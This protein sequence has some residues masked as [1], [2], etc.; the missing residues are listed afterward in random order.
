MLVVS[1]VTLGSPEQLTGGYLYHR[2]MAEAA[3]ITDARVEFVSARWTSNPLA[4]RGD[5][6]VV[7]SIAAAV[8]APWSWRYDSSPG[9]RRVRRPPLAAILHQPPGGI[10]HGR[11]HRAVQA[12]LDRWFYRRCRLLLAASAALADELVAEH[13]LP[14]ERVVVVAPGSDVA[15]V[16]AELPDLRSGRAVAFL[17]VG[18]WMARKGTLELLDAFAGVDRDRGNPASGRARRRR[19]AVQRPRACSPREPPTSS[20]GSCTTVRSPAP[21][22]RGCTETADAFVLPSYREPYG[23]VYGEALAAGLPVVGWRAGNLP[24]LADDGREGD[25]R[26]TRRRRRSDAQ[27]CTAWR[28]TT[29]GEPDSAPLPANVAAGCRP[30]TTQPT[31]SSASSD[32][33]RKAVEP[34]QHGSGGPD[35]EAGDAGVLDVHAPRHVVGRGERPGHGRLDRADV[36]DD[37]DDTGG[38]VPQQIGAGLA[39][40]LGRA[41]PTA[42]RPRAPLIGSDRHRSHTSAGTDDSDRPSS[43]P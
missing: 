26:P 12:P 39:D 7:D 37:D 32:G 8:V 16:P 10:D 33:W 4:A 14:A 20:T 24:H 17:S 25:H 34:P 21:K 40:T 22:S 1:L 18:N 30:G 27:P 23:T 29:S 13:R 9:D 3:P 28:P 31:S 42:R 41:S 5:V 43:S 11:L 19:T 15:P 2:R 35:V 38:S 36:S 6:V